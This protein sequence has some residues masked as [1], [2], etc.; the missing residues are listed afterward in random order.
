MRTRKKVIEIDVNGLD[1]STVTGTGHVRMTVRI[2]PGEDAAAAVARTL[3]PR[4]LPRLTSSR[5]LLK[6]YRAS[7]A[8]REGG[9]RTQ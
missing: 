7:A 3:A 9:G 8:R 2:E 6:L 4:I 5:A 1:F